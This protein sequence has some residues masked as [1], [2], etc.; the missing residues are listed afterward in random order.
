MLKK[1]INTIT[2]PVVQNGLSANFCCISIEIWNG[3]PFH[4][5]PYWITF[6]NQNRKKVTVTPVTNKITKWSRCLCQTHIIR[7]EFTASHT[8]SIWNGYPFANIQFNSWLIRW[9]PQN[10]SLSL[11]WNKC[12][13][14][15]INGCILWINC[16]TLLHLINY[17]WCIKK[18]VT[19]TT[20]FDRFPY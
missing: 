16:Q 1:P 8:W 3:Y 2:T 10:H 17:F 18:A 13:K 11:M 20:Q 14:T 7:N 5:H 9:Y 4:H 6:W 15:F 12:D 19:V